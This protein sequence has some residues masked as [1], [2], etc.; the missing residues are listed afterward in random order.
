LEGFLTFLRSPYYQSNKKIEWS[1]FL[2]FLLLFY[3]ISIPL[4]LFVELISQLL[5]FQDV[6][7][8]FSAFKLIF[9]GIILAPIIEE[10]QFR[11]LLK[12]SYKNFML[13]FGFSVCIALIALLK[14]RIFFV[15]VFIVLAFFSILVSLNKRKI[16]RVQVFIL[17]N[18]YYFFYISCILFGIYH[19]FNYTPFN[20]KLILIMPILIF[21]KMILGG[22][23][24]YIR[25]RFGIIYSIVFHSLINVV[26][27]VT[28]LIN[29]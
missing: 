27:I 22:F 18:Y 6:A 1:F 26:P 15:T 17:K 4:G 25:I 29:M 9:A 19:I 13:F 3:L 11:L 21:P 8:N 16:R 14:G 24:G 23:L 10:I 20:S 5:N 7:L 2:K 28:L 12:P